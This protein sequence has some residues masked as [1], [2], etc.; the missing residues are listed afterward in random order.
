M[1]KQKY[2]SKLNKKKHKFGKGNGGY[3]SL[4]AETLTPLEFTATEIP[5]EELN[6]TYEDLTREE[7][8]EIVED[9]DKIVDDVEE[10][11][12]EAVVEEDE[13]VED[14]EVEEVDESLDETAEDAPTYAEPIDEEVTE[15]YEISAA[16]YLTADGETDLPDYPE[17]SSTE[18]VV[19]EI[20]EPAAEEIIDEVEEP[21][22][23]VIDEVEAPATEEVVEEVEEPITEE[24][25][26]EVKEPQISQEELIRLAV[27]AALK[28]R[29]EEDDLRRAEEEKARLLKEEE[30]AKRAAEEAERN[31]LQAEEEERMQAQLD[32]QMRLRELDN[33]RQRKALEDALAAQREEFLK[34]EK[35]LEETIRLQKEAEARRQAEEEAR[36]QAEEEESRRQAEEEARRQAEEEAR[37]QAEEEARR[38]AEEEARR[39]AEEEARRQ[40]EEEARRQAEEEARIQ[41]EEEARRLELENLYQTQ[42]DNEEDSEYSE[43]YDMYNQSNVAKIKV[44]GVGGAGSNAVN[45]MI[46]LGVDT[47][48]FVAVNTDKQALMLS[49]CDDANKIQIG[50]GVTKGL[51]AG[52]D[53]AVGEQSAEESKKMLEQA[54]KGVDLLFIAAGMGGGTGTGAAPIVAKIAKEAECV[55]VAVVTRPFHFEGKKREQNAKKGIANLAKYVDTIIIIPND[56]LLEALPADTPFVDALKYADDTLRQGICGIA[57]LIATP[58]LINLDFADVRT[59]LKNQGLAHMGVGRAKGENRVIEAVR[60]AVASPLLETTIE[61]A[62]GIILN[63]TGGKDLS[64]LQV[65]EAADRVQEIIDPTANIIFGMNVNPELQEE[66]IITIIATGFDKKVDDE[67]NEQSSRPA[68]FFAP[69]A[70]QKQGD[71]ERKTEEF[72]TINKSRLENS[73]RAEERSPI[74]RYGA[75][76]SFG[77][78]TEK[79]YEPTF[80][81]RARPLDQRYSSQFGNPDEYSRRYGNGDYSERY[82]NADAKNDNFDDR[83]DRGYSRGEAADEPRYA[84]EPRYTSEEP[85]YTSEKPAETN[86]KPDKKDGLPAFVRRMFGKK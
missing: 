55:T 47:A 51:G 78:K 6:D 49:L 67:G 1:S 83:G 66:I 28:K 16:V 52:A 5:E 37:R 8:D 46:E 43:D 61:G 29:D 44:I 68:P 12:E 41:A 14:K 15:P 77:A 64:M 18:E 11:V 39:Q 42:E 4:N 20:E 50:A 79:A 81:E 35:E 65:K 58:S 82:V 56:R 10:T 73:G 60:Q 19:D 48:E 57:D 32:E 30:T 9:T 74:G 7:A 23:E 13:I 72:M 62:H 27:E 22:E 40:A 76:P 63:V 25:V 54:V 59:I 71:T 84:E 17:E 38:Q 21:V 31:R 75:E 36:R 33:I 53:P 26:E 86:V 34:R 69:S 45:R 3:G 80:P 2:Q 70:S 85:R 24:V